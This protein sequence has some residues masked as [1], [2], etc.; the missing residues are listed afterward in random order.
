M[1]QTHQAHFE[2]VNSSH[3]QVQIVFPS[4]GDRIWTNL[5]VKKS[6][7]LVDLSN[8]LVSVAWMIKGLV[9][10]LAL[11]TFYVQVDLQAE[12]YKVT[13]LSCH[14]LLTPFL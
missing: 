14:V 11:V 1:Q 12:N 2:T 8:V 13:S 4:E 7:I 5:A 6:G 9:A 3:M 10:M